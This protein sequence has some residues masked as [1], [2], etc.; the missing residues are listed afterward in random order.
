[1]ADLVNAA[2]TRTPIVPTPTPP[3]VPDPAASDQ[4]QEPL[5]RLAIPSL[6]LAAALVAV[7]YVSLDWNRWTAYGSAQS[8]DD[9]SVSA[10]VSTIG[11]RISGNIVR[12]AAI[13]YQ[14]VKAGQLLAEID[15]RAYEAAAQLAQANLDGAQAS[16]SNLVNQQG[17]QRAVVEAASAQNEAAMAAQVQAEQE[18]ARQQ[19]LGDATSQQQLQQSQATYLQSRATVVSTAAAID[20]QKA[21]LKVLDGQRPLLQAQV[22][23]ARASLST[24][25]L[26]QSYARIDAPF[27]GMLGKLL[28]HEGDFVAVGSSIVPVVPLPNVYVTANFK[29]TQLARMA[30]G[31][32][33]TVIVDSFPGKQLRG[34]VAR[35]SPASGSIFAL[36][37]PDNATGNFTKVVQRVAIRVELEPDQPMVN[38]LRPGMSATVTI[39]VSGSPEG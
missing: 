37:P 36:L 26:Q 11:A 30:E 4:I 19:R 7:A 20:Q 39:D 27:D 5:R 33:A 24:A 10:D 31:S 32:P 29:E 22:D 18:Y 9:A 21:Q 13:D 34:H 25:R 17:L 15:P 2:T 35:L 16:L 14:T 3:P 1:M 12:V 8:T 6:A 28:V 23:A 38:L